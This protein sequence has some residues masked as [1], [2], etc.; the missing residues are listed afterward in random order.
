[1]HLCLLLLVGALGLI[2][3]APQPSPT[4]TA[5]PISATMKAVRAHSFGGLDVL[6]Y[7]ETP[8]PVP[9]ADEVLIRVVAAGVNPVDAVLRSGQLARM[10]GTKLPF[11]PGLDVAGVIAATGAKAT[12]FKVGDAVYACLDIRHGGG[13]AEYAVAQESAASPKPKGIGF[14]SAASMP[15]AAGTAWQALVEIAKLSR[16][17]TVLIHGGSGGVGSF[18]IQIAKARG[19]KVIATASSRNQQFLRDLGADQTIDYQAQKFEDVVKEVD[20]VLDSVGGETL[21]RSYGLVK[22]GGMIVSL[23]EPPDKA[24]LDAHT[25]RGLAMMATPDSHM[26]GALAKLVESRKLKPVVTKIYPLAEAAKA[27]E[28]IETKH[29]R[30]KIVLRVAPEP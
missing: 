12:K 5:A 27:Q 30:G 20:V 21:T 8:R 19:A 6:Q 15:V 17:Q 9:A 4:A 7:E 23:L 29:T 14:E 25:V 11:T 2:P 24:Q 10:F 18:A 28:A 13:Y 22:K 16:G 1:M 26:L 3:P